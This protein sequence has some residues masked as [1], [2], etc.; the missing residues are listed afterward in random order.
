MCAIAASRTDVSFVAATP[1]SELN[2]QEHGVVEAYLSWEGDELWFVRTGHIFHALR[3]PTF[4]TPLP[5]PELTSPKGEGMPVI[6]RDGLTLYFSSDRGSIS[7]V[8]RAKRP[9]RADSFS[10]PE[11]VSL[12]GVGSGGAAPSW[13]SPD[14]CRLYLSTDVSVVNGHLGSSLVVASRALP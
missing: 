13:L 7:Q 12:P 10:I 1:V 14:G 8:W 5:V 2:G 3:R 4:S 11:P 9:K 6:T